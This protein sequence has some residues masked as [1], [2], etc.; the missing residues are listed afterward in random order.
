MDQNSSS[1]DAVSMDTSVSSKATTTQADNHHPKRK[2]HQNGEASSETTKR[3]RLADMIFYD[4]NPHPAGVLHDLH[5]EISSKS[6]CF[7]SEEVSSKQTRFR[8]SLSIDQNDSE[9]VTFTGVGRSKQS[10]KNMAAQVGLQ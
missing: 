10:A 7:D 2:G 3:S 1:T 5:P 6:Y 9:P 8:C 4:G